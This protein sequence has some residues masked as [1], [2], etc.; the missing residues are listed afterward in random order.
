[1]FAQSAPGIQ[2]D[3]T[4][5]SESIFDS[6]AVFIAS[7]FLWSQAAP[8][9]IEL[10]F[11]RNVSNLC[12]A[13]S[14]DCVQHKNIRLPERRVFL[15]FDQHRPSFFQN[16]KGNNAVTYVGTADSKKTPTISR[17]L[18]SETPEIETGIFDSAQI[19]RA[20]ASI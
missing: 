20:L 7:I 2:L 1:M 4:T 19:F 9:N 13:P 18:H 10:L 16:G 3:V 15:R 14:I 6:R 11:V 12:F 5:S 8:P 17:L